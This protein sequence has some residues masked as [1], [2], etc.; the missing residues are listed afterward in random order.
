MAVE[1]GVWEDN[2]E[3]KQVFQI[4]ENVVKHD[5]IKQLGFIFPYKFYI[6]YKKSYCLCNI[7]NMVD[8]YQFA[9]ISSIFPLRNIMK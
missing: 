3:S 6:Y 1:K 8:I 5:G 4:I 2:E 7:Y 9:H